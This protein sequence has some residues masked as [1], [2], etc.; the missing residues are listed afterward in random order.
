MYDNCLTYTFNGDMVLNDIN[1]AVNKN[2]IVLTE[3]KSESQ[4]AV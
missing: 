1:D 2:E 4:T 3:Y